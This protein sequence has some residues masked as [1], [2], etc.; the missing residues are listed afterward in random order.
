MESRTLDQLWQSLGLDSL[1]PDA[2]TAHG[3]SETRRAEWGD[4][5]LRRPATPPHPT[6]RHDL[7]R[8]SSA[9]PTLTNPGEQKTELVVTGL[10]GEGGM[11]R[12]LLARQE[13]LS[14]DVAVK[15]THDKNE[16]G[17]VMSLLHEALTIGSLEHPG[18]IPLY[19]LASDAAGRPAL[20]MKRV[21]GVSW[22]MLMR[23]PE[24]P[25]WSRVGMPGAERIDSHVE[26]LRQVCNAVA[27][28]HRQG[29]LHRDLKPSNVLIGEFGEVY[30]ADWGIAALKGPSGRKPSLLGTPV[31]LAPEMVT[32]DDAEMDERTDVFLL[33]ATLYELLSGAPPW[34]GPDLRSVLEAAWACRPTA[35]PRETPVEL[36]AICRKAMAPRKAD[37]YQTALEFREALGGYLRHR[38]SVQLSTAAQERLQSLRELTDG[39]DAESLY[40]LLSECRFGFTQALREWPDNEVARRGL[41]ESIEAAA[42]F[43]LKRNN[44]VAA[45]ALASELEVIPAS[46]HSALSAAER[47]A[48]AEKE[49]ERR[50]EHLSKEMDPRVAGRE[51]AVVFVIVAATIL[52]MTG[53]PLLMPSLT[54]VFGHK[55]FLVLRMSVLVVVLMLSV[56]F[57]RR[58]LLST[59]VNRRLVG[60]LGMAS[61]GILG[62]RIIGT[63]LDT[64]QRDLVLHNFVLLMTVCVTGGLTVHWGFYAAAVTVGLAMGAAALLP[65]YET[66]LLAGAAIA[67]CFFSIL[68]WRGW[69]GELS[70]KRR[71][72]D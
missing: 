46:L 45:R 18:V 35:L 22:N 59:R 65:G 48:T 29:V 25:L 72:D 20:V 11:G 36:A 26:I 58:S 5:T 40:R 34:K 30:V 4:A 28:A 62:Q 49:R 42:R 7:P 53:L 9:S 1:P 71:N 57:G 55:W 43:E 54:G 32:G 56:W 6:E 41:A 12:V 19:Q 31:Y 15:V 64:P 60:V 52:G 16:S 37:R 61:V 24:D 51:R 17:S 44:V 69:R 33:G 10:L 67:A 63:L 50:I 68:S 23:N 8:L 39:D 47:R 21:D 70:L 38:G 13:S 27:Y 14:R 3:L 66:Y 2:G